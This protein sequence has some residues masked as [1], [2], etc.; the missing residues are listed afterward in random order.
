MRRV[1]ISE[2]L[3]ET[4]RSKP[5][6]DLSLPP[7]NRIPAAQSLII[8][9]RLKVFPSNQP[10]RFPRYLWP[11]NPANAPQRQPSVAHHISQRYLHLHADSAL[12]DS[13]HSNALNLRSPPMGRRSA[14]Y[15]RPL[16]CD[17]E[18]PP[19]GISRTQPPIAL[20]QKLQ[21][22]SNP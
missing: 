17:D 4:P 5:Q 8:P 13:R 9:E 19:L 16:P 10:P 14:C 3:Q 22:P 20:S 1:Y 15:R 7:A 18:F 21:K 2:N 11:L 12:V 6:Y